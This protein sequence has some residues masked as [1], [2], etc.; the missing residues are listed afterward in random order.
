MVDFLEEAGDMGGYVLERDLGVLTES[1]VSVVPAEVFVIVCVVVA[2]YLAL[3][4]MVI[5]EP[6]KPPA[7]VPLV[8]DG[9]YLHA[10][11]WNRAV[12]FEREAS[13]PLLWFMTL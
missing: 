8:F 3:L 10:A 5:L 12:Q 1:N 9:E 2:Q 6:I 11:T 7:R 13:G 4:G